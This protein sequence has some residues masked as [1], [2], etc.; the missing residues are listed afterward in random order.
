MADVPL[1]D[2]AYWVAVY[3][4]ARQLKSDGCSGVPDL[5]VECC[6]EHDLA[7]RTGHTLTCE[8]ITRVEADAEFR[9][10]I[11]ARS[12]L[13]RFSPVSWVRWVGVRVF[14]RWAGYGGQPCVPPASP[15]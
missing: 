5:Y 3:A 1:K 10:C 11:Q 15:C 4:R 2:D 9:R 6:W 14:G 7:Y 12:R 13:R 8:P